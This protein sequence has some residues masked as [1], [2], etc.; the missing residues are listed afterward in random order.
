MQA[1]LSHQVELVLAKAGLDIVFNEE[2]P[3]IKWLNS[4]QAVLQSSL[5]IVEGCFTH[6]AKSLF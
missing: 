3:Y 5:L 1:R 2:N 6:D 4:H